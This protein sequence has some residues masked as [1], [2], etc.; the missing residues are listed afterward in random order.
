MRYLGGSKQFWLQKFLIS[1]DEIKEIMNK[2][3][4]RNFKPVK[5]DLEMA[6]LFSSESTKLNFE[7]K[8][9]S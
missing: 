6:Q 8:T 3:I 1:C 9:L 7:L 5:Q 2:N 4:V